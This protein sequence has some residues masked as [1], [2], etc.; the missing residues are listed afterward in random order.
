MREEDAHPTAGGHAQPTESVCQLVG[1]PVQG[2][3]G[4]RL[5]IGLHRDPVRS[6]IDLRLDQ[7]MNRNIK[8]SGRIGRIELYDRLMA[9]PFRDSA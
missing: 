8:W 7:R 3:I 9:S 6:P 2:A 4:Q 5:I 1:P